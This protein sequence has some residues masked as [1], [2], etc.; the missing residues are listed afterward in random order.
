MMCQRMRNTRALK[1]RRYA[2]HLNKL[3]GYLAVFTGSNAG[4][5]LARWHLIKF[6]YIVC[7]MAGAIRLYCRFLILRRKLLIG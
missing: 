4:K 3:N 5:K 6:Y 2:A 1:F 7:P